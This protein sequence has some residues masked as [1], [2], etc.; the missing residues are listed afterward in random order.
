VAGTLF[1]DR[2]TNEPSAPSSGAS[3]PWQWTALALLVPVWFGVQSVQPVHTYN[4]DVA[5]AALTQI[6]SEAERTARE[7]GEV[8]FIS[9]PQLL[10]FKKIVG[11]PLISD[12]EKEFLIEMVMANNEPYLTKFYDDLRAHRFALI[13][14]DTQWYK[15]QE[16]GE[17]W[18]EENN[19]WV[20]AITEPLLCEYQ[21]TRIPGVNVSLLTPRS[22]PTN[23][24]Y[25]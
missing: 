21:Q 6:R 24:V 10:T 14:A 16:A 23:C 15:Y 3:F 17:N 4:S 22:T 8:L 7:G 19:L 25:P 5:E 9:Q 13:V 11:V 1:W 18:G 20:R 2:Q 12:Y